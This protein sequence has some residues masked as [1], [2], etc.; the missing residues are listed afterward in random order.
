MAA[1]QENKEDVTINL[2]AVVEQKSQI[3]VSLKGV[4]NIKSDTQIQDLEI[5]TDLKSV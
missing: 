4:T 3:E 2:D 5:P 1:V